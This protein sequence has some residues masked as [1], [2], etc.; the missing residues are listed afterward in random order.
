MPRHDDAEPAAMLRDGLEMVR[1]GRAMIRAAENM[2]AVAHLG[3]AADNTRSVDFAAIPGRSPEARAEAL[4]VGRRIRDSLFPDGL[5]GEPA[6]DILLAVF[7]AHSE[8]KDADT[9]EVLLECNVSRSTGMRVVDLLIE[10]GLIENRS[11][12]A[13]P[14]RVALSTTGMRAI[15]RFFEV[16]EGGMP[17][18]TA[19][20]RRRGT[21]SGE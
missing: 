11:D 18:R 4:Y 20:I 6:W 17:M 12:D 15:R 8:G 21:T 3:P 10:R 13:E 5:F 19:S 2:G 9:S 16:T 14:S 7:L 1:K